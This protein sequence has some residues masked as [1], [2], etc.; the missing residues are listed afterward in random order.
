MFSKSLTRITLLALGGVVAGI[1]FYIEGFAGFA[2][3][4]PWQR[5]YRLEKP[6]I[7]MSHHRLSSYQDG[8]LLTG[9]S[10]AISFKRIDLDRDTLMY[11][12]QKTLRFDLLADNAPPL[13]NLQISADKESIRAALASQTGYG[14]GRNIYPDKPKIPVTQIITEE[15]GELRISARFLGTV[16]EQ[17]CDAQGH[18]L[19]VFDGLSYAESSAFYSEDG[20]RHWRWLPQ[21]QAPEKYATYQMLVISAPQTL[22]IAQ[23]NKLYQSDDFGQHWRVVLDLATLLS[24]RGIDPSRYTARW[25]YKDNHSIIISHEP[26]ESEDGSQDL[27]H[28]LLMEFNLQTAQVKSS[29]WLEGTMVTADSNTQGDFFFVL[30]SQPR[31]RYSLNQLHDDGTISPVL[32]TG[33]K[34]LH[35]LYAGN[36][37]LMMGKQFNDPM[38]MTVSTDN[39]Q[40]WFR[41]KILSD[42]Y[43][44]TVLFDRWHNRLFRFPNRAYSY[45]KL[46]NQDGLVYETAAIN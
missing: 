7:A 33:K 24:D 22:L 29:Q 41:M 19:I 39:G 23:Q 20:G 15:Q 14:T 16:K 44:E 18:C 13:L 2:S 3:D 36:H 25:R 40:H 5:S 46:G 12:Y 34:A 35:T 9:I 6:A 1:L 17:Q 43:D 26:R 10:D 21:W 28:S 27:T 4:W 8:V 11:S 38:H 45:P 37:L 31:A 30:E 32:E 42:R